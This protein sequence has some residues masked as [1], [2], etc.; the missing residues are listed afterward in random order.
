MLLAS[1]ASDIA[2][3]TIT[4]LAVVIGAG[5][6]LVGVIY[7]VRNQKRPRIVDMDPVDSHTTIVALREQVDELTKERDVWKRIA[8]DH[9]AGDTP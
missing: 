7:T 8:L 6:G 3:A 5:L 2:V 9:H 1:A 4:G